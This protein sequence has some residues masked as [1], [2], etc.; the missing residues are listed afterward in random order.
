MQWQ[1][2]P[3]APPADAGGAAARP[4]RRNRY[5]LLTTR[6]RADDRRDGRDP[7]VHPRPVRHH[8]DDRL[9]RPVVHELER[10]S[11]AST[12]SSSSGID[13]Y[14]DLVTVY[15]PFFPALVHNLIWLVFFLCVATPLGIFF[16]VL[17]DKEIRVHALLPER[18][19]P[20]GRPV[21]GHRR[22]HLAAPVRP[23]AGA[24]Q[25]RPGPHRAGQPDLAGWATRTSTCGPSSSPRAGARSAT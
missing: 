20:A 25:Q 6:D 2:R 12:R 19:V 18:A 17:L 15:K 24:H 4:R 10:R 21:A 13:N 7:D 1:R 9:D 8:P 22:L 3:A 23:R 14:E 16:A 11:A 5:S